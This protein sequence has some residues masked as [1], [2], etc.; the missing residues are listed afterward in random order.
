MI[1]KELTPT[2]FTIEQRTRP[3]ILSRSIRAPIMLFLA[4]FVALYF[5]LV[6]IRYLSS[7]IRVFAYLKN[8][9]LIASFFGIGLGMIVGR[10][11]DTLK[12]F[13]PLITAI[14]FSLLA[15][16]SP[17]KLTHVPFPG[18]DYRIFGDVPKPPAGPWLILWIF[19]MVLE[20]F[21]VVPGILYLV[22]AFFAVLGG[23]VGENLARLQPLS[24]YAIN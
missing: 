23:F 17:L 20:Y 16:A 4:T 19:L 14:F 1:E 13:F 2:D 8:L 12:R 10:P 11:P 9:A 22:V 3:G 18:G 6:I 21:A 24:G 5:E 15:F 7:E